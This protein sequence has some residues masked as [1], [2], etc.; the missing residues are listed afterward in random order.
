MM[1]FLWLESLA[2]FKTEH[3]SVQK[4]SASSGFESTASF[5]RKKCRYRADRIKLSVVEKLQRVSS[6]RK[7]DNYFNAVLD[8]ARLRH[9]N[10]G[11]ARLIDPFLRWL[12]EEIRLIDR[13]HRIPR[14]SGLTDTVCSTGKRFD[15]RRRIRVNRELMVR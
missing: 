9:N 2:P 12:G 10:H 14:E 3:S 8:T 11:S 4:K 13:H 5:Q 6:C 7:R 15:R 1:A